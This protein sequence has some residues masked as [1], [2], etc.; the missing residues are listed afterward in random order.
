MDCLQWVNST[1]YTS[2]E[3]DLIVL[4]N[5]TQTLRALNKAF[6]GEWAGAPLCQCGIWRRWQLC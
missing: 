5:P 3:P 4:N 6:A 1:E 2:V